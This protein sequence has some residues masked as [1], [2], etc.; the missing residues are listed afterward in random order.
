VTGDDTDIL[1]KVAVALAG[2]TDP[3][4]IARRAA[5]EVTRLLGADTSVYF[6]IDDTYEYAV[7]YGG[8]HVP[9]ALLRSDLARIRIGDLPV[10]I[11]NAIERRETAATVDQ[12]GHPMFDHPFLRSLPVRPQSLLYAPVLENARLQGALV[13]YWW[14]EPHVVTDREVRLATSVA[15]HTALALSASRAVAESETRRRQAEDAEERYRGLFERSLAG[16]FRTKRDGHIT[17]CNPA[18]ARILGYGSPAEIIGRHSSEFYIEPGE[19]TKLLAEIES[20]GGTL[21]NVEVTLRRKDGTPLAVLMNVVTPITGGERVFEGQF[22]DISDRRRAEAAR[23]EADALRSVAS[24]ANGAAHSINNPLTVIRG[25]LEM[26]VHR[27][28][29]K[30]TARRIASAIHA[31]EEISGVI[32]RMSRITHLELAADAPAEMRMLDIKESAP[33]TP[34]D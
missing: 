22:L 4:E 25:T 6:L 31:I 20:A 18:F 14:N 23:R 5:R 27:P 29:E 2:T 11:G 15:R 24:L 16:I 34:P 3:Q 30:V 28:D 1:L 19:R 13:T 8:Y 10:L 7:A 12:P 17:E 32:H 26:L 33:E 9:P 21:A